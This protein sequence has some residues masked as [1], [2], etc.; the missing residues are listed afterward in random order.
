MASSVVIAHRSPAVSFRA[1]EAFKEPEEDLG[2][3]A[4]ALECLMKEELKGHSWQL[5]FSLILRVCYS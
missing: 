1:L 4:F 3:I 5:S 2:L